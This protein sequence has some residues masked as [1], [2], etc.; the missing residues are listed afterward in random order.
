MLNKHMITKLTVS[1]QNRPQ[2]CGKATYLI[3]TAQFEI[4]GIYV[5]DRLPCRR[6]NLLQWQEESEVQKSFY[7]KL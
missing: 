7:T 2:V 6:S 4:S 1:S 3:F 5:S